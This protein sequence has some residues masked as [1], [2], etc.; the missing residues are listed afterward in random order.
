[1]PTISPAERNGKRDVL[2]G[3]TGTVSRMNIESGIDGRTR[4]LQISTYVCVC[5]P[6]QRG[7]TIST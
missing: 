5:T 3:M 2:K 4:E 1:M 7:V 6:M